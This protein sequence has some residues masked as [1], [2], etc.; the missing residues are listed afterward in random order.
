[1]T[2]IKAPVGPPIWTL[3]PLKTDMRKPA[4][5]AVYKP[6]SGVTPDAIAKAID[7]GSATIP[8]M[9]PAVRSLKNAAPVYPFADDGQ[10]FRFQF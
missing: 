3:L 4:I 10:Q 9:M 1:M 8:T 5:M 7:S 6:C 2:T